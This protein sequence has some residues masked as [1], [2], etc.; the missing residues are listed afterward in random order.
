MVDS[1]KKK[2]KSSAAST[3]V[4]EAGNQSSPVSS[5]FSILYPLINSPNTLNLILSMIP[6]GR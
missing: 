1:Q 6:G 2:T 4:S 5:P 3:L